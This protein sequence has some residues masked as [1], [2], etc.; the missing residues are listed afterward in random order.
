MMRKRRCTKY[1]HVGEYV[2]EVIIEPIE[3]SE[4]W[5][6]Y[7]SVEDSYVLDDVREVLERSDMK[8]ASR[9]ARVFKL[10]PVSA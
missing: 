3:N 2:A 10:T 5:S 6:P 8:R 7:L 9:L 4:G 1:I